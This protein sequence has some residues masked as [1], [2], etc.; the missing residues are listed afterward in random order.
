MADKSLLDVLKLCEEQE[1]TVRLWYKKG[2]WVIGVPEY[3][4]FDIDTGEIFVVNGRKVALHDFRSLV[5]VNPDNYFYREH[6]TE[7]R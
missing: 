4:G 7:S 5:M 2:D 3:K 1:I 6:V